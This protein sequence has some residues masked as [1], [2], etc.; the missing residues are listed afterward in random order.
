MDTELARRD[1]GG[2]GDQTE[3]SSKELL[4][5]ANF[6]VIARRNKPRVT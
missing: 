6:P 1:M 4:K 5:R 3:A 2:K